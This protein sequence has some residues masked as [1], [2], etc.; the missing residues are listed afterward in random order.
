MFFG[1]ELG[2]V[3]PFFDVV[4]RYCV[5]YILKRR[6][7]SDAELLVDVIYRST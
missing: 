7:N 6:H 4:I 2:K 3:S 1:V 5:I